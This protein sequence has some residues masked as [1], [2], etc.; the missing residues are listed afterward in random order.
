MLHSKDVSPLMKKVLEKEMKQAKVS[1]SE[2]KELLH[3]ADKAIHDLESGLKDGSIPSFLKP[4]AEGVLPKMR[5][6]RD[7]AYQIAEDGKNS[8]KAGSKVTDEARVSES[9]EGGSERVG[10][11]S[12]KKSS[13]KSTDKS[14]TDKTTDKTTDNTSDTP[15]PGSDFMNSLNRK[16]PEHNDF[17]VVASP[18]SH[19]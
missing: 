8:E 14:S 13:E 5:S 7:R 4:F 11:K 6:I 19:P 2:E 1:G 15:P 10:E 3:Q 17:F 9:K 16:S 18:S 12:A